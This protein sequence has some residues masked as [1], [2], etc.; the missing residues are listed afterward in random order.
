MD[1]VFQSLLSSVWIQEVK[2]G[3]YPCRCFSHKEWRMDAVQ[4]LLSPDRLSVD[5]RGA[6]PV[7]DGLYLYRCFSHRQQ[8]HRN[9][10]FKSRS[11]QEAI[12]GRFCLAS[13]APSSKADRQAASH[14]SSTL[15]QSARFI[16]RRKRTWKA[17]AQQAYHLP[18]GFLQLNLFQTGSIANCV[19]SLN[20]CGKAYTGRS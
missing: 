18:S 8:G 4:R 16:E 9:H 11:N 2:D 5:T 15:A 17:Q 3:L 13:M 7:K 10:T 6:G 19:H 12:D 1:A 14:S 20:Q